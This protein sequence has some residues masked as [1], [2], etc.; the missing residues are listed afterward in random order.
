MERA[1][2]SFAYNYR[3]N[4]FRYFKTLSNFPLPQVKQNAGISDKLGIYQLLLELLNDL[5]LR[6]LENEEIL[7]KS[8]KLMG[9]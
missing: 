7:E 4:I 6:K 8:Q 3:H 9:I 5:R 1:K 2:E